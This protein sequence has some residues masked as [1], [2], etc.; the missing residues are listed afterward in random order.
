MKLCFLFFERPNY[1]LCVGFAQHSAQGHLCGDTV[2]ILNDSKGHS[3]LIISDGMGKGSR[4][5]LDGAMGAGLLSKLLGAGFGFDSAL[6]TVNSALLIKSNDESLATLD[7]AN[8]DLFTGKCEIYKAGAPASFIIRNESLIRCELASMPAGILRGIE[9]AK[10]TAVLKLNDLIVLMSD[11]ISELGD[12][13]LSDL[14]LNTRSLEPQR[15]AELVVEEAI[16]IADEKTIDDMS[17]IIARL[18]RNG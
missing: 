5:A 3:I 1:S 17:I 4:A 6:K 18:E 14:L 12:E 11:G 16:K 13:W 9:F 8:I 10:R 15:A 7:V 2:K